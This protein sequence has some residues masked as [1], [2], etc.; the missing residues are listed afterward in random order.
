MLTSIFI[1]KA[2]HDV[3]DVNKRYHIFSAVFSHLPIFCMPYS[4]LRGFMEGSL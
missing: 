1:I 2:T 3:I 4:N